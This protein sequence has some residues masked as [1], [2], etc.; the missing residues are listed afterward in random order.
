MKRLI[1]DTDTA[2]DD[3]VAL[4]MALREPEVKVEAGLVDYE[5]GMVRVLSTEAVMREMRCYE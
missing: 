4:I 5:G 1:I 2:S 3:A